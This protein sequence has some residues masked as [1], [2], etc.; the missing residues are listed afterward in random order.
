MANF[1]K[2][3]HF[4]RFVP[5]LGNNLELSPSDQLALLLATG[6]TKMDMAT[7]G[8]GM[9]TAFKA[10]IV[11]LVTPPELP[12]EEAVEAKL[13]ALYDQRAD[14]LAGCWGPY[15]KLE[16]AGHSI[17]GRPVSTLRDYIR[18]LIE[19]PGFYALIE[20]ASEVRRLNS[21]EGTNELFS[22]ALSGGSF[23]TGGRS[24]APKTEPRRNG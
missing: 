12:A 9:K 3:F 13:S 20:M 14:L 4:E 24:S 2:A 21:V 10:P 7:F 16:R 18:A 5:N 19:Q 22:D 15:A 23:G 17:E 11:E 8:K 1:E 6:L